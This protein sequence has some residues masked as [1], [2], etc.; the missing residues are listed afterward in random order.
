MPRHIIDYIRRP[1]TIDDDAIAQLQTLTREHPYFHVARILLLQALY[2]RH[3]PAYDE[4]LRR[5]AILVPS[6]EAI[7]HLTE[8]PH[9]T[10][11]EEHKR[12][13]DTADASESRTVSL[14]DNSSRHKQP[15]PQPAI[16]SMQHRTTSATSSSRKP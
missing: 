5:T 16:P 8:E 2:R 12:Y 7:F 4:T 3:D 14:I 10:Q 9:Y 1:D 11:A 15:P 6:R 13:D